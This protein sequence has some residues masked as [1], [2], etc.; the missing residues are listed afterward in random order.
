MKRWY[1][2]TALADNPKAAEVRLMGIIGYESRG[3]DWYTGEEISTGGAGTIQEFTRAIED[4][5]DVAEI[6]LLIT[7][8]G[9][10]VSTG[11]AIHNVLARHSARIV[12]TIDGYAYS[13]ATVIAMAADEI[14]IAGNGLMMIHDAEYSGYYMDRKSLQD[15]LATLDAMNQSIAAAYRG[16]AGGTDEEWLAR[17]EQTVWL[18]GKQ[19]AEL[20]LVDVV[21]DDV[22][23]T[24]LAPLKQ[25]TARYQPP[26]EIAA[27]IDNAA[28]ASAPPAP[29][30]PPPT[31]PTDDMTKEEIQ[32]L[33]SEGITTQITALKTEH[34]QEVEQ[35]KTELTATI[36]AQA[37]EIKTLAD[38]QKH[39]IA[40]AT[41]AA[42]APVGGVGSSAGAGPTALK[43]AEYDQLS[44]RAKASF[45]KERGQII[46]G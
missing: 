43:K 36:T 37:A 26:P 34:A 9:G 32:S 46:D 12:C 2:V 3:R 35:L 18:T 15:A 38:L 42:S 7:S 19:A 25:T 30:S 13:I 39:G 5:G 6:N 33:I 10:D 14:R 8:E 41:A 24:A 16:K 1:Q 17:M 27:L 31:A 23:M 4:L 22:A 45:H 29:P 28:T 21:T 11:I 20:G 40:T 44:P